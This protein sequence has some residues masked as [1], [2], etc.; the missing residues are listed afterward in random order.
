MKT[1]L[2]AS[3]GLLFAL[4]TGC[5]Q[6]PAPAAAANHDADIKAITADVM[7]WTSDFNTRDLDKLLSHYTDETVVVVPG[8]PAART[9][10]TRRAL[11]KSMIEDPNLK[12]NSQECSRVEVANSGEM[13]FAQC[14]YNMTMTDPISK[15][16]VIDKGVLVEVYKKQADGSWRTVSDIASSEVPPVK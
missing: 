13:G 8:A 12:L 9:A 7:R 14:T 5:S 11:L 6:A 4:A 2:A 15:K 3:A 1:V 16:P 10:E